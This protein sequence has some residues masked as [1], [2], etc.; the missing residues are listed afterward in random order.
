MLKIRLFVTFLIFF[1]SF[2]AQELN[3]FSVESPIINE[4]NWNS[5]YS[6]NYISAIN[7]GDSDIFFSS[8]NSIF[9]LY[10][11][12]FQGEKFDTLDGLSGDEISVFHFSLNKNLIIVGY[13]NGLIQIINLNTSDIINV[14]DILNKPTI[15]AT[16]KKI[17]HFTEKNNQLFISTGYGISVYNL[18]AFEFGDTFYIGDFAALLDISSTLIKEEYI[19]AS[20][21]DG[22]GIRRANLNSNL[23]DYNNWQ[24]IFSGNFNNMILNNNQIVFYSGQNIYSIENNQ[25][26]NILSL[27]LEILNITQSDSKI[28]ITTNNKCYIYNTDLDNLIFSVDSDQYS[29]KFNNAIIE[30]NDIYIGTS[31]KGV[32]KI[33]N[34]DSNSFS[35]ML[36]NGPLNNNIFSVESL[37]NN[38]WVS[39]GDYTE[40][41]NPYPLK[42]N[43]ISSYN[44]SA[45]NWINISKDSISNEAVNL[46]NIS[47]N[48]FN[49]NNVFVSSF[50]GGLLELQ[51][52]SQ[53]NF[54][55]ETNS[56]L[57][58]LVSS[59]PQYQSIRISDLEFDNNGVLWLLNSR[60]DSPLKS[61][62]LE[63]NNWNSYDFTQIINDG[64]QDELGFNDIEVD[65]YGNKWIASLRSGLIGFNENYNSSTQIRKVFSQDQ[66]N[67]PS[68]NVKSIAIDNN[69]HLWIGTI[70]GLRVLYNTSNFFES[71]V[72]TTQQI[73]ILEDGIPRELLEQQYI[74][75][76]EVDG[77][78]NKW[79]GT[80]GSGVFYFSPNGQQTIYHFTKENSPL[81]SNN[82]NDI[83][84]NSLNGK[85][86]FATDKG[87]VSFNTG[88]SSTGSNFSDAYVYPNPVR[89]TFNT[90]LDKIK[91]SGLTDNINIKITD[92][93]GN[94]VGEAQSNI[95]KRYNNFN[96]E[97]DGGTAFWNG[98][99]LRNRDV[100]S[101]VYIIMLSDLDSY[102]TKILKL[103]IIR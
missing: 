41:F 6:Y 87:L 7:K 76:I 62:N 14:Y 45:N 56:E 77:A 48:P 26:I 99:N 69:N 96:L 33:E 98:K 3:K 55:N 95:N 74:S 29:T 23:I 35:F 8:K 100:S 103:M 94:L 90:G 83:S 31:S 40:Y 15:P 37:N 68:S 24:E 51:N 93:E 64:F 4:S 46:N 88:S 73:V 78:N 18:D 5:Y 91:I 58:S 17:N 10:T 85:V 65:S 89:P 59:D 22:G 39:Y 53:T 9:S 84:V 92:I 101:G 32:L 52:Y 57:E 20:S 63:S 30:Q 21:S 44:E 81:P 19:Y 80:I 97:I 25:I 12:F 60:V 13:K 102:E 42:F 1:N 67:M 49:N 16:N 61:L 86:F 11:I 54:Y 2:F 79:V 38:T 34:L 28:I 43:G 75:D 72:V 47:V 36:P 27:D 66:S 82:I 70:Q 50:H 71:S